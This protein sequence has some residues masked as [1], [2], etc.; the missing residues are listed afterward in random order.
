MIK[1]ILERLKQNGI[2]VIDHRLDAVVGSFGLSLVETPHSLH[3][4]EQK[5]FTWCAADVIG[6]PAALQVD[7]KI[8]SYC[9]SCETSLAVE[10]AKGEFT[11]ESESDI[12]LWIVDADLGKSIVGCT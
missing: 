2:V 4:G 9:Y 1:T 7:A 12:K 8:N 10:L 11:Y 6:I 3:I 5:L